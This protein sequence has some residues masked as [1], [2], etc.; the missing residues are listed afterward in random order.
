[1]T[2]KQDPI[3]VIEALLHEVE[4]LKQKVIELEQANESL[5]SKVGGSKVH[6]SHLPTSSTPRYS[7][8]ALISA[9]L[10]PIAAQVLRLIYRVIFARRK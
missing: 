10:M 4:L 8:Q 7:V 1:M 9:G 2:S 6:V 3:P 5:L